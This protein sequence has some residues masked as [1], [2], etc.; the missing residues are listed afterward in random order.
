MSTCQA[1]AA[2]AGNPSD[3]YGGFVVAVPLPS[4]AATVTVESAARDS[5]EELVQDAWRS[6]APKRLVAEFDSARG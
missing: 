6:V 1:R 4:V 5:V 3:G 2:L